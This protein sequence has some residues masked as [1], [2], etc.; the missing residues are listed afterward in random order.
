MKMVIDT[1]PGIDDA[2]AVFYAA[3]DPEI[4]LLG[5]TSVFGN[6]SGEMA[7]RNALRLVEMTGL[8]IPVAQGAKHA[9]FAPSQPPPVHIHGTEGFGNIPA[10]I[11]TASASDEPA[12]EFLSRMAREHAGELVVCAIGPITNIADTIHL[13]P[14]FAGNVKKIVF[15][16]GAAFVAGNIT[17]YAEANSYHD[18]HAFNQVIASGAYITMVGLDVTNQ[19]L[20][21][22]EDF[23]AIEATSPKLGGFL[24]E[25]SRFYLE[26]YRQASG[27]DGCK[28]HDPAAVIACTHP[29][30]FEMVNTPIIVTQ[31]G[32][33]IGQTIAGDTLNANTIKVCKDVDIDAVRSQFISM[34]ATS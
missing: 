19:I 10:Q 3:L 27:Q 7:A 17:P 24:R 32:D 13:D 29:N 15:M 14:D 20:C 18:P 11:P 33:R 9:L 26:F 5:L 16:G 21:T 34:F 2:M 25:A 22:A 30:L 4:E 12:A 23:S 6:V 28:L 31:S 1:D 8:D